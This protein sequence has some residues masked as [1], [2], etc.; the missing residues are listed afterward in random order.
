MAVDKAFD[1]RQPAAIVPAAGVGPGAD[2]RDQSRRRDHGHPGLA[3]AKTVPHDLSPRS[4]HVDI[5]DWRIWKHANWV[6]VL[7]ADKLRNLRRQ[8]ARRSTT[9]YDE[10]A[11]RTKPLPPFMLQRTLL[12]S[13]VILTGAAAAAR[14][15]DAVDYLKQVKPI[16]K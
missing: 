12:S 4:R 6:V 10:V 3:F 13:L 15:D 2:E 5:T 14:G 7:Q 16:L 1:G 8:V 11:T 9:G